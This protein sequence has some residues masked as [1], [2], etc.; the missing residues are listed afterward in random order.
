MIPAE[1]CNLNF[2]NTI[3]K[4]DEAVPLGNG[5][6]G[7]LIWGG[8]SA[9]RFSIDKGDLWDCTGGPVA[10]GGVYLSEFNPLGQKEKAKGDCAHF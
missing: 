5:D 8:P 3:K 9:L 4:W 10:G 7:C 2:P 6:L 1:Y